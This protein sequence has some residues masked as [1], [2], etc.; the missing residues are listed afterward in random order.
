MCAFSVHRNN[1]VKPE[2]RNGHTC[3]DDAVF[4]SRVYGT[5]RFEAAPKLT[6]VSR[7]LESN[8]T[9]TANSDPELKC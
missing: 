9:I 7:N 4:D 2:K 1:A 3:T 5:V 8:E 6:R